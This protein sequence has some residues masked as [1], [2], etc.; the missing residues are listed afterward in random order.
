MRER[1]VAPCACV[2]SAAEPRALGGNSAR[3]RSRR[4]GCVALGLRRYDLGG[5]I[6]RVGRGSVRGTGVLVLVEFGGELVDL[7]ELV[8]ILAAGLLVELVSGLVDAAGDL[9]ARLLGDDLC[10]ASNLSEIVLEA[11]ER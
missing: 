1:E 11:H 5:G 4:R 10:L 9:V 8:V 3:H 7:L 2:M 6:G